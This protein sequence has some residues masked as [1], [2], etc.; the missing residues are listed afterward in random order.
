MK[1]TTNRYYQRYVRIFEPDVSNIKHARL[2]TT[3]VEIETIIEINFQ[4]IE[5]TRPQSEKM[6]QTLFSAKIGNIV[7][8]REGEK[9]MSKT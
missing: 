7:L 8:L 3:K 6:R 4:I 5:V 2:R 9:L 1:N